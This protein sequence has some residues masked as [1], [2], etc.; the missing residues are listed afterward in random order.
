MRR[1]LRLA[2]RDPGT[3]AAAGGRCQ[4]HARVG[5]IPATRDSPLTPLARTACL[6]G[7]PRLQH[8]CAPHSSRTSCRGAR[9]RRAPLRFVTAVGGRRRFGGLGR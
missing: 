6:N 1:G 8:A 2:A 7:T 5:P 9:S 3:R 4:R